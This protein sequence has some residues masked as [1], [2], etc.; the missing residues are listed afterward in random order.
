MMTF[1]FKRRFTVLIHHADDSWVAMDGICT[2][3]GCKVRYEPDKDRVFCPCHDGVFD[4]RTGLVLSGPPEEPLPLY[5]VEVRG[6]DI[7]IS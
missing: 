7:L 3:M 6:E 2:H 1:T 4:S 5:K